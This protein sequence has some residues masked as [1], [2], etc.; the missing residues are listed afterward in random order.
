[1]KVFNRSDEL[2]GEIRQEFSFTRRIYDLFEQRVQF[3]RVHDKLLSIDFNVR[4]QA[5][6]IIAQ[7]SKENAGTARE[8]LFSHF[9]SC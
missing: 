7:V 5:H 8:A 9:C 4:N 3:G 1:M 2:I 6:E